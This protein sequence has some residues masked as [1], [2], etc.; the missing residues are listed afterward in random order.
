MRRVAPPSPPAQRREGTRTMAYSLDPPGVAN[1]RMALLA[2]LVDGDLNAA[3]ALAT[4][5]LD[6]GIP[7]EVLASEVLAPVQSEL[8]RRWADGDLTVADEHAATATTESLIAIIAGT[9][10]PDDG[11]VVVVTC[12]AGDSHSLPARIVA[13]T[14]ALSGF[15]ALCLGASMPAGDLGEYLA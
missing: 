1:A 5:L 11:P 14:L 7:F 10:A 3:F 4:G 12:A 8:G 9:V 6:E 13:A 15:R 2:A